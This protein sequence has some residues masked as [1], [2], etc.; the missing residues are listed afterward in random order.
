MKK[1]V[2]VA[3]SGGVDSSVSALLLQEQGFEV[4]GVTMCLGVATPEGG[5]TRCCGASAIEDAKKVCVHLGIPHYVM[6]FSREL[7]RHV[8]DGFLAQYALGRTPNPCV[9]CN[10][11]LKFGVLFKKARALGFDFFATGHYARIIEKSKT[12][13]L[14]APQERHKDQTYFLYAL[15]RGILRY[16]RFPLE[17][18]T[19]P[20]VRAYARAAGLSVAE[21][22]ESQD[23]CF[24]MDRDYRALLTKGALRTTPGAIVDEKGI[25]R[26]T[27]QGIARYT[28]GQR[29]NI[30]ISAPHALYVIAIDAAKN[31]IVVGEK[32]DLRARGFIAGDINW[33]VK[34]PPLRARAKIRY[35]HIP[36]ACRIAREGKK[37]RVLFREPQ[38]AITPG[39][40]AVFYGKDIVFGGGIIEEVIR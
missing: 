14:A 2:L 36:A 15:P 13:F 3:M 22:K 24:V 29:K 6:D 37:I 4:A 21:K 7:K 18:M 28:I 34:K 39:Q 35:G 1:K 32:K 8:I 10:Q 5:K 16:I 30:G 40:S 27:H 23:I 31:R 38:E 33:L 9:D 17:R 20:Q 12:F 11:H 19:K 25:V 26:G